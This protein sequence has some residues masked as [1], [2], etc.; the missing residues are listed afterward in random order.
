[1]SYA[2][3][4]FAS[5]TVGA[6]KV[7]LGGL[8]V[9]DQPLQLADTVSPG[10]V[11]GRGEDGILGLG[12]GGGS[13]VTTSLVESMNEGGHGQVFTAK[14]GRSSGSKSEGEGPFYTFGFVDEGTVQR[15]IGE[16]EGEV[17]VYYTPVDG[18]GGYWKIDSPSVTINGKRTSRTGN[19]AIVDTGTPLVL[20]DDRVCQ[21]IYDAIPGAVYDYDNQ[22]YIIP[23][24]SGTVSK[25][26]NDNLPTVSLA[27]GEKEFV[28]RK[29]DLRVA[30]VDGRPGYAYGG[31]QSRGSLGCD[32]FGGA[33]LKGVY[34]VSCFLLNYANRTAG[35]EVSDAIQVFDIGNLRF[36]A[37]QG[38]AL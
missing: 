21:D 25:T 14:L 23:S 28:V 17:G 7:E 2:D 36:G 27:V 33:F 18:S 6:D 24:S 37:V 8:V 30:G 9:R 32:V 38:T 31:I 16:G 10:F 26:G 29:E 34:A 3:Q 15:A 35:L 5:G 4:S 19:K 13:N 11:Q 12:L 20:I 22:G 1:M